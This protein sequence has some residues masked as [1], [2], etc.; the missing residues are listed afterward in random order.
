MSRLSSVIMLRPLRVLVWLI[1]LLGVLPL[2]SVAQPALPA[3]VLRAQPLS[4]QDQEAISRYVEAHLA[5][6]E[7]EDA[8]TAQAARDRL[9]DPVLGETSVGFRLYYAQQVLPRL[10]QM[11]GGASA[12]RMQLILSVAGAIATDGARSLLVEAIQ[13][14]R[15]A[16]RF[17]AARELGTLMGHIDK[18]QGYSAI[19]Q[20][21]VGGLLEA[22]G[23][24][25]AEESDVLIAAQIAK[26]L[27][28]PSQTREL[29]VGA[30]IAMCE[31]MA[32]QAQRRAVQADASDGVFEEV[33]AMLRVVGEVQPK[34][35]QLQIEGGAPQPLNEAAAEFAQAA[36]EFSDAALRNSSLDAD[37]RT[38]TNQL[39]SAA[40]NLRDLA[41]P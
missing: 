35:I 14:P 11:A 4:A 38:L 23:D 41:Q 3:S 30:L 9:T 19:N 33:V 5:S 13:D 22:L 6:L 18:G 1:V 7:A 2:T 36:S 40:G 10:Q 24:W 12:Q 21:A 25:L 17:G 20:A 8:T 31:S 34:L 26:A 32:S 27:G 15:A 37:G 29:K 39:K 28:A 16:V